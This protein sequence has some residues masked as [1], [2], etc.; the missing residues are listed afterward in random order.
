MQDFYSCLLSSVKAG[1]LKKIVFS[2]AENGFPQKAVGRL[3]KIKGETHLAVEETLGNGKVSHKNFPL[4]AINETLCNDFTKAYKQINILTEAGDAEYR[5]SKNGKET[6][7]GGAVLLRSLSES[8][9]KFIFDYS[10]DRKKN[11]ILAGNEPFLSALGI[12]D[13]NGRIYDKKQAKFRQ[14]NRFLEH[15]ADIVPYLPKNETL[16]IYDLCCGKSYLAFAVY[17]YFTEICHR[18]VEMLCIDLKEDV[19]AFCRELVSLTGFH[20]MHFVADDIRKTPKDRTPHLVLSLHACDIATDI[21]LETAT[22]LKASVILSTPCCH[23][24]L[25]ANLA[26]PSLEFVTVHPF[27]KHKLAE[28]LT[29]ALRLLRLKSKG[30][31]VSATELTDPDDTPKNTLLRAIRNPLFSENSEEAERLRTEYR[32]VLTFLTGEN[33]KKYLNF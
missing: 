5:R 22:D 21:V 12:S 31:K 27:L 4:S 28:S 25:E 2:K 14:I 26:T 30:Y 11:Y 7:I 17:H 23:H 24:N 33:E 15:I 32:Q 13:K 9:E 18:D 19:I 16:L 1:A 10:F 6:L 8:K 20:G 3:C 29:D